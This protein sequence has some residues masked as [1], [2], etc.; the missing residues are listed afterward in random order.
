M[1]WHS[2]QSGQPRP[3]SVTLTTPP[4]VTRE[5]TAMAEA[6]RSIRKDRLTGERRRDDDPGALSAVVR[7]VSG[8]V[9]PWCR[10]IVIAKAGSPETPVDPLLEPG[11]SLL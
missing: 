1:P 9:A 3:D 2:G 5:K 8:W 4:R 10:L 7:V 6:V 11:V